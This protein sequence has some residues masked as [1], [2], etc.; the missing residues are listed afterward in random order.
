MPTSIIDM[1][2]ISHKVPVKLQKAAKEILGWNKINTARII[3]AI[4]Q[5][6]PTGLEV[7]T[8]IFTGIETVTFIPMESI[9]NKTKT[10]IE[11]LF[12]NT[13]PFNFYTHMKDLLLYITYRLQ[14]YGEYNQYQ[15]ICTNSQ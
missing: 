10:D 5:T 7:V 8:S 9:L 15:E 14:H 12:E 13:M 4:K 3:D 2:I 11:K 6:N 1:V